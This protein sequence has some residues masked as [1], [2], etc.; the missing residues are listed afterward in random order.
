L[1]VLVLQVHDH[2]D[3]G[4]VK[5]GLEQVA[6][7]AQPVQVIGAIA[8]GAAVR[9]F[10][11]ERRQRRARSYRIADTESAITEV[12]GVSRSRELLTARN[13]LKFAPTGQSVRRRRW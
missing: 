5:S 4:K 11:T 10:R 2:G 1:G 9:T 6:D 7:A 12:V 13:Q 3:A 8:A